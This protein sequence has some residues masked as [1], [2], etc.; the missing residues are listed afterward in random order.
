MDSAVM[1]AE[2]R[3]AQLEER[4]SF[5]IEHSDTTRINRAAA[6]EFVRVSQD[7]VDCLLLAF[8]ASSHLLGKFHP[9]MGTAAIERKGQQNELPHLAGIN[10]TDSGVAEP[11]IALDEATNTV[12][13]IRQGPLLDLG[14]IGK[15][16]ALDQLRALFLDW[17]IEQGLLECGGSTYLALKAL[18]GANDWELTIG[19]E[20]LVESIRLAD[21]QA[22]ASSGVAYQGSH[23]ID[24]DS[25]SVRTDWQRSYASASTAAL[26]DAASTAA[27]LLESDA[28][29][30][31]V[32]STEDL[33]FALF[34]KGESLK[35]GPFFQSAPQ[36]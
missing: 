7:T 2:E 30:S 12:E 8:D 22:L 17:E 20:N 24:P 16:F 15:G 1:E 31:V 10:K 5:Y 32:E 18:S 6:G 28:L 3:L 33:S 19:Y 36:P 27:L 23:V 34:A 29:S 21:G 35:L 4:L 13:K 11:V 9:F 14:G 26:A 25:D